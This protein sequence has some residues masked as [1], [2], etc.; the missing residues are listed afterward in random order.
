MRLA[1]HRSPSQVVALPGILAS[2]NKIGRCNSVS[3]K[4]AGNRRRS[5][6]P[7]VKPGHRHRHNSGRRARTAPYGNVS[8]RTDITKTE[9]G[10]LT[11]TGCCHE[12]LQSFPPPEH[13]CGPDV[14]LSEQHCSGRNL[15]RWITNFNRFH[16]TL[17]PLDTQPGSKTFRISQR[18]ALQQVILRKI[19]HL[20]M[21]GT[22]G[23]LISED[24]SRHFLKHVELT[25]P[26]PSLRAFL[27][28]PSRQFSAL[29]SVYQPHRARAA[30][31]G[32]SVFCRTLSA[33]AISP[34][35]IPCRCS[36]AGASPASAFV[37][38]GH[39]VLK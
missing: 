26:G 35:A 5:A 20:V 19:H 36:P 6:G 4:Q 3:G 27:G 39:E 38:Q 28:L 12:P 17:N 23:C 32:D 21:P 37:R 22:S 10:S 8:R 31:C 2:I 13:R 11:T 29:P 30:I 16:H 15:H 9:P 14:M 7:A 1:A 33:S 18:C 34:A 24:F 25:R